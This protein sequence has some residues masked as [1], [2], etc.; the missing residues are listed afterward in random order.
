MRLFLIA[1][2]VSVFVS[3]LHCGSRGGL[4][5]LGVAALYTAR[6]E[7]RL[8]WLRTLAILGCLTVCIAVFMP[9]GFRDRIESVKGVFAGKDEGHGTSLLLRGYLLESGFR[10]I[11]ADPL[12]GVGLGNFRVRSM[13]YHP[14]VKEPLPAHNMY[15]EVAAEVGLPALLV[16]LAILWLVLRRVL[17]GSPGLLKERTRGEGALFRGF[18]VVTALYLLSG[19]LR[20]CEYDAALWAY[21]GILIAG[22]RHFGVDPPPVD[23]RAAGQSFP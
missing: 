2:L 7:L 8:G 18:L 22:S 12:R 23:H 13:R 19:V 20:N 16:L 15:V 14:K 11:R 1:G 6:Q 4:I 5:L 3:I 21:L 9:S 10:M 17:E